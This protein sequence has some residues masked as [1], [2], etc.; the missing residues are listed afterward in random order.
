MIRILITDFVCECKDFSLSA[1]RNCAD[2]HL[3]SSPEN[4]LKFIAFAVATFGVL[5]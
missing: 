1:Q 5:F 3:F 2:K 4:I